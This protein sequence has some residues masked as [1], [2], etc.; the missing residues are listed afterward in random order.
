M[1]KRT[2]S[3]LS[4]TRKL[5]AFRTLIGAVCPRDVNDLAFV[6]QSHNA[7]IYRGAFNGE[8][9]FL[10]AYEERKGRERTLSTIAETRAARDRMAGYKGGVAE[11]LWASEED[12]IVVTKAVPG[13]AVDDALDHRNLAAMLRDISHWLR[14]YSGD[15]M[16]LDRLS[17]AYWAR[18]RQRLDLSALTSPDRKLAEALLAL[19][20]KRADE[21]GTLAAVTGHYPSD[22]APQNLHWTGDAIWGF[23]LEGHQSGS[24]AMS[25]ARMLVLCVE[26][27]DIV[28][29]PSSL[30]LQGSAAAL[31][32]AFA[33]HGDAPQLMQFALADV[34]LERFVKWSGH[35]LKNPRLYAAIDEH[36]AQT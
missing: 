17:T 33:S 35:W 7:T 1:S 10:K 31:H 15:T 23:D 3:P 32:T 2:I 28:T 16:Y 34:L 14:A 21:W 22:F 20:V 4:K 12:R 36:L 25:L 13:K 29:A 18:K 19:Q 26:R 11:V 30:T 6:Q 5:A 8:D 27:S 9:V 24:L